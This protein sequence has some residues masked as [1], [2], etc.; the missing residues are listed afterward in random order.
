[1][2][3]HVETCLC[4][5]QTVF[6]FIPSCRVS[7][8]LCLP[9][10][11]IDK[12]NTQRKSINFTKLKIFLSIHINTSSSA[13]N[14]GS[15]CYKM[16]LYQRIWDDGN[17]R[18]FSLSF[19]FINCGRTHAHFVNSKVS[20]R[21]LTYNQWNKNKHQM[22]NEKWLKYIVLY[23]FSTQ[24]E[25]RKTLIRKQVNKMIAWSHLKIIWTACR[26]LASYNCYLK[27]FNEVCTV[28]YN[29]INQVTTQ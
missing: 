11:N 16:W 19:L 1:M 9:N 4:C 15:K 25:L 14:Q 3:S 17:E 27:A 2:F 6:T 10:T 5:Y 28:G 20:N 22:R 13:F 29:C 26:L 21:Q 12:Q 8:R 23:V 24:S 7:V 18:W